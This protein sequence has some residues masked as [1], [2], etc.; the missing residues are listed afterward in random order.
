M[1]EFIMNHHSN[2]TPLFSIEHNKVVKTV[3]MK[4]RGKFGSNT[5]RA[6]SQDG[7]PETVSE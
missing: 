1:N 2:I 7:A 6:S 3:N 5:S 4:M